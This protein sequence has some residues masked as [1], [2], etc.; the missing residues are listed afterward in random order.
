MGIAPRIDFSFSQI[1]AAPETHE[2]PYVRCAL[3]ASLSDA[4]GLHGMVGGQMLDLIGEIGISRI[5]LERL[6]RRLPDAM[7]QDARDAHEE[8][9]RLYRELQEMV[10]KARTVPISV[11]FRPHVRT[12]R[13]LAAR[14]SI[15][16]MASTAAEART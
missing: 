14:R 3:V 8:A 1:L 7:A 11:V 13:D 15:A 10:L 16:P 4:S 6:L 12:V 9:E 2:D 5:R